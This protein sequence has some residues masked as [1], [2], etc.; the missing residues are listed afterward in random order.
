MIL[1]QK[2]SF[3]I[4]FHLEI[5]QIIENFETYYP[6]SGH[7]KQPHKLI[8][9]K[10]KIKKSYLKANTTENLGVNDEFKKNLILCLVQPIIS[11]VNDSK[12][13]RNLELLNIFSTKA[14]EHQ[15]SN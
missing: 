5:A 3:A 8:E 1:R 14:E 7:L 12:K 11:L 13:T 4:L 2:V 6:F 10:E 15:E 9:F